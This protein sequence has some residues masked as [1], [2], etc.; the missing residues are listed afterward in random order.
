MYTYIKSS[1]YTPFKK[2]RTPKHKK[3][4][5]TGIHKNQVRILP[6]YKTV[7]SGLAQSDL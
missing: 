6:S 4:K 5:V 2:P 3:K 1:H 7:G